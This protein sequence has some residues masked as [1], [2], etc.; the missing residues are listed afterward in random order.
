MPAIGTVWTFNYTG[1]EQEFTTPCTGTY[2]LETWGAQGGSYDDTY[3]GGYGGYSLGY[4]VLQKNSYLYINVG[5]QG[6]FK[7]IVN[8][9][10]NTGS[11]GGYNGGGNA[12]E[13]YTS[14][15]S[16]NQSN[17]SGGGATHIALVSGILKD[18]ENQQSKIIIISGGGGGALYFSHEDSKNGFVFSIGG[19]GGGINGEKYNLISNSENISNNVSKLILASQINQ[20]SYYRYDGKKY[21]SSFGLATGT[22]SGGG[23][24]WYGGSGTSLGGTGGSGYIGNS[25]LYNKSMYCYNCTESAEESTKTNST[26]C[27]SETPTEN[28][29][30]QGDG[31]AKI[32]LISY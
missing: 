7:K 11:I 5:G 29:S 13:A 6:I 24:G 9:N 10:T 26:T 17:I 28:C 1:G 25:L 8:I 31:Y 23:G 18:L 21:S 22:I 32:T 15:I 14:S 19:A 27:T 30:K 4:L 12:G 16:A 2:K 20:S 3:Y